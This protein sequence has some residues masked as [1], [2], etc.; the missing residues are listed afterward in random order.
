MVQAGATTNH[1]CMQEPD[2]PWYCIRSHPK[3][4][5]I[6][7]ANLKQ[8]PAVEVFNPR[9]RLLRSTRRG[10]VWSTEPVFPGYLFSRFCLASLLPKVQYTPSI[11]SVVRFGDRIAQIPHHVIEQLRASLEEDHVFAEAPLEGEEVE[12]GAG[13][14]E[15]SNGIVIQILPGKQRVQVLLELMGRSI[16]TEL[17]LESVLFRKRQ[18]ASIVLGTNCKGST[19]FHG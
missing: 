5:H 11:H 18:P 17:D 2:G 1:R 8:L 10:P 12:I 14:L 15:G 3:H 19:Y 7:A 16:P 4:E 9:L 13:P 6:A